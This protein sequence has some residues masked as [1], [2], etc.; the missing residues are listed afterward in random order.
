[1]LQSL[2][3]GIRENDH[4][5]ISKAITIIENGQNQA[6]SLLADIYSK[7]SQSIRIGITGPPGAGKSTIT[8]TLVEIILDN[9][10]QIF[11]KV[12]VKI[13]GAPEKSRTPNLQIRSPLPVH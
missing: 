1:M 6:T 9:N 13:L 7:T 12:Y 8:N 3:R 2:V 5:S 10:K 11:N 4:R